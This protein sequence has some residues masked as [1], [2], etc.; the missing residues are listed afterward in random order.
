MKAIFA[1]IAIQSMMLLT[2]INIS[3]VSVAFP[4][5]TA[6]FNAP[7]VVTGWVLSISQLVSA[8]TIVFMGKISDIL[9]R[10]NTYIISSGLFVIGSL[11]SALVPDIYLLI[12]ARFIQSVGAGGLLPAMT[13]ITFELFPRRRLQLIG[14]SMSIFNIGG[15]IG[16]NIGSWLVT[17]FGWQ[18]VFWFNV[19]I[20]IAA[21]IP[22]FFLLKSEPAVKTPINF[23]GA[24]YLAAFLFTFMI[25]L[26]QIANTSTGTGWLMVVLLFTVSGIFITLF[27]RDELKARE[28]IV[29]LDLISLKPFVASNIFN[30]IFG[31]CLWG[32]SSFIPL[33]AVTV[34]QMTTAQSGYVLMARSIGAI[35]A[36]M[37]SS[38]FLVHW[39]YRKPM[40]LG[41]IVLSL[42]FLLLG[43][44]LAHVKILGMEISPVV[45][46]SM[47]ALILGLG[48]GIANPPSNIA[49]L[50]LMPERASTITAVIA[51]FRMSGSSIFI[52][53]IALILQ[54]VGDMALGFNIV[55]IG[56]SAL[57]LLT[58]PV[59]F[60]MPEINRARRPSL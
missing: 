33:Y 12:I 50:E 6:F 42:S 22:L 29:E 20:G 25:G 30:F 8:C 16:P 45:L 23:I 3:A 43:L 34:Y 35:L 58:I 38:L 59:I 31:A 32:F 26:S 52:A 24:S 51:M 48:T 21:T 46:I 41:S 36:S 17:S 40:L 4:D 14:L 2:S 55:F 9:G 60:A 5:I 10:K 1:Y 27:I 15:V 13:G 18:S 37:A 49:C 28:P 19:P 11:I 47:M 53:V 44:E 57:G 7:I 54:Y 39:S 56:M